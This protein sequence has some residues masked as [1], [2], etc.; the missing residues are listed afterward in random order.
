MTDL[1]EELRDL[2]PETPVLTVLDRCIRAAD[3]IERLRQ[4][5]ELKLAR[6]ALRKAAIEACDLLAERTYGNHARSPGHNARLLLERA[7]SPLPPAQ[8]ETP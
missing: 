8:R 7:L 5:A 2:K 6:N 4:N 3:E 1:V